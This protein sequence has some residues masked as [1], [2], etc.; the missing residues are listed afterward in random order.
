LPITDPRWN[1]LLDDFR[2][3][4]LT[5]AEFCRRRGV[6]LHTFRKRLVGV[7]PGQIRTPARIA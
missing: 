4:G 1:A 5:H 2:N 3:S 6:P 7:T